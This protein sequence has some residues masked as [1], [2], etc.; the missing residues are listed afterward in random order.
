VAL[1]SPCHWPMKREWWW[2]GLLPP[3]WCVWVVLS[4]A[5][6]DGGGVDA[7]FNTSISPHCVLSA[8]SILAIS[9]F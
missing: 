1:L 4:R 7:V 8:P 9:T 2:P 5:G 3:R 6:G